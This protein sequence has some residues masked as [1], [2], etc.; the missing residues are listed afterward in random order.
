MSL[1]G[2]DLYCICFDHPNREMAMLSS[3]KWRCLLTFHCFVI[4]PPLLHFLFCYLQS[5]IPR[6]EIDLRG[7]EFF[8]PLFWIVPMWMS[9]YGQLA[10]LADISVPSHGLLSFKRR[11]IFVSTCVWNMFICRRRC[12]HFEFNLHVLVIFWYLIF[13]SHRNHNQHLFK[14]SSSFLSTWPFPCVLTFTCP[15]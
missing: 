5:Q 3:P 10:L 11:Y 4:N 2:D 14:E 8:N 9:N 6:S 12:D 7:Y 1:F 15:L 13:L